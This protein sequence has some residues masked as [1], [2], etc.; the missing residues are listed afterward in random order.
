MHLTVGLWQL[1][2]S[3]VDYFLVLQPMPNLHTGCNIAELSSG[4]VLLKHR[5]ELHSLSS[6]LVTC[7]TQI[8]IIVITFFY[9]FFFLSF[10][11]VFPKNATAG[12]KINAENSGQS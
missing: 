5:G 9:F 7:G 1:F 11:F 6:S 8:E 4:S 10:F 2:P 3:S 12:R